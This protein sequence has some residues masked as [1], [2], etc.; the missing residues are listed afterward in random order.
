MIYLRP[1]HLI[2]IQNFTGKG[3]VHG[4][5]E[6]MLLVIHKLE[7][8]SGLKVKIIRGTDGYAIAVPIIEAFAFIAIR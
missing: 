5:I 1:Y 7:S 2:C 3:Y 8:G 6:N 4:F